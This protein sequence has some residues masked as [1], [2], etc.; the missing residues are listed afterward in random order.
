VGDAVSDMVVPVLG[1]TST[2]DAGLPGDAHQ[3]AHGGG[4]TEGDSS[5][6][7]DDAA[8]RSWMSDAD[9]MTVEADWAAGDGWPADA[10][11]LGDADWAVGDGWPAD[12]D[13][14]GDADWA[15]ESAWPAEGSRAAEGGRAVDA[16]HVGSDGWAV[17]WWG[18][19]W[20]LGARVASA[21]PVL[22][23]EPDRPVEVR[24]LAAVAAGPALADELAGLCPSEVSNPDLVDVI[25]GCERLARWAEAVQA[26]AVAE[27]SR[28]PIYHP[29]RS[30]DGA[31]ELRSAGCEVA[32]ALKLAPATGEDRVAT[33]RRLVE[34]FP[35]TLDALRAGDIDYRRAKL[36]TEVADRV[37]LEVAH[38][39]EARVLPKAG[40]RTL[41]QHRRAV[42][43]AILAVDPARA[44]QRLARAAAGR[45]VALYPLEDGMGQLIAELTADGLAAVRAVLDAAASALKQTPGEARSMDQLRADA[46]VEMASLSLA[47]GWLGGVAGRGVRLATGQGRRPHIHVTVPYSTLIGLDEQPGELTGY[48]P[49]PASIARRIAAGG[50]WRRLLTDPASGALLDYGRTTY[51]PPADLRDH[52]ITRD[53]TCIL[54][55]CSQPAHRCQLDHTVRYPDGPTAVT[56]L[57]PP[58]G[59]HH[60][61]KTR[62]HWKLDQPEPGRF[63]WT[64]PAGKT[65]LRE[66]EAIG[67][68]IQPEPDTDG[69]PADDPDPTGPP[70][71]EPIDAVD[72]TAPPNVEKIH[73]TQPPVDDDTD[74]P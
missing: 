18:D 10:D 67:P 61:L 56:N 62:L 25:V 31:D 5:V 20:P 32:L 70:I 12:A 19:V 27:L 39:V 47:S 57:G 42:E 49:I 65:Y 46:L 15:G 55:V 33:A 68:I 66:P 14:P 29:D 13:R 72:A 11:R 51:Q 38:R 43:R 34:D 17:D 73:P 74:P 48:G 54:P 59:P 58:C 6:G 24:D 21:S 37:D 7:V 41:G 69:P 8:H 26:A 40:Q 50:V 9:R 4:R 60:D 53:R 52:V 63:V 71:V 35:A 36:I 1:G 30:R 23:A 45:R 22:S 3:T 16:E 28:R 64:T 2:A 44:E